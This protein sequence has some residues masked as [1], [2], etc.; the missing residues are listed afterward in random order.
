MA[1]KTAK[2]KSNTSTIDLLKNKTKNFNKEALKASNEIVEET[3]ATGEKW[4]NLFA[5]TL[6]K[7]TDLFGQQQNMVLS[8]LE[9]LKDHV[10]YSN[11]RLRKLLTFKPIGP[12]TPKPT[13]KKSIATAKTAKNIDE[14]MKAATKAEK[15][16][17]KTVAAKKATVAKAPKNLAAATKKSTPKKKAIPSTK[18]NKSNLTIIEG[19]GPKTQ[20]LLNNAGI[21]SFDQLAKSKPAKLKKILTDAGS[22][23]QLHDPST[24]AA[25]AKLAAAGKMEELKVLQKEL[26]G[27]R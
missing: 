8:G 12:N 16:M 25:Q 27:G 6:V 10:N 7:S 19:I 15:G 2:K 24:W 22:R 17:K 26:K 18:T 3:L 5:K 20:E 13:T 4:Q 11:K 14:V 23:F 1:T 9:A 21:K